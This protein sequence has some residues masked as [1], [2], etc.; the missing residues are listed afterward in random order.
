MIRTPLT[1]NVLNPV[2]WLGRQV[3][4]RLVS[5]GS[6]VVIND[7]GAEYLATALHVL[8]DCGF[9][10]QV[11]S[12]GR[13]QPIDWQIIVQDEEQDVAVLKTNTV[14]DPVKAPVKYGEPAGMVY[15]VVGYSLGFPAWNEEGFIQ[16]GH[17]TEVDGKPI[18]LP[19]IA[20]ANFTTPGRFTYSASYINGGYS[21][22]A[23]VFPLAD[24]DWTIAGII[25]R[26]P[27]HLRP[28]NR[29]RVETGDQVVE[30]AG[31]VG[32]TPLPVVLD[33]I[34]GA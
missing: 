11:R 5:T 15:G 1:A 33:L 7:D 19:T 9:N 6:G 8:K 28:V 14:L 22:G 10:P 4:G 18:P 26:F 31:L 23:V 24:D 12:F 17:I 20:V 30:H 25:S 16:V 13:W 34:A 21:G 3:R 27:G 29:G 32:Y 2:L